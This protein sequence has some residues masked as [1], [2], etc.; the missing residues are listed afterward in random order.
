MH[1]AEN[2]SVPTIVLVLVL[3]WPHFQE[4][5]L[6]DSFTTHDLAKHCLLCKLGWAVWGDVTLS[7][8][9]SDVVL[10]PAPCG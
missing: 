6:G 5:P 7:K 9:K 1:L 2:D 8:C 4:Y 3:Q 10:E